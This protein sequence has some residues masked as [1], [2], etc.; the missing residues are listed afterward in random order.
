MLHIVGALIRGGMNNPFYV[1][2]LSL[3]WFITS[4]K[5]FVP[6]FSRASIIHEHVGSDKGNA[7]F[8]NSS[9]V[10]LIHIIII[11]IIL[12]NLILKIKD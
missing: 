4:A 1:F 12:L 3:N 11:K 2:L 10:R 6:I 9:I 5:Q 7:R 8:S